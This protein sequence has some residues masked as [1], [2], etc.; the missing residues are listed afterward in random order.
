MQRLIDVRLGRR[1]SLADVDEFRLLAAGLDELN[2]YS[3][4]LTDMNQGF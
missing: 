3:G 2:A 4:L 1:D